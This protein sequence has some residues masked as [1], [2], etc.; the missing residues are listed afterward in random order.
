M[1]KINEAIE[2]VILSYLMPV[3]IDVYKTFIYEALNNLNDNKELN[4]TFYKFKL[5][6]IKSYGENMEHL[7]DKLFYKE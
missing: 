4:A 7:F 6:M 5:F 3:N 2:N 1:Y